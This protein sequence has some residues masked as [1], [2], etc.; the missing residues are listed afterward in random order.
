M[1]MPEF[2]F[3][4]LMPSERRLTGLCMPEPLFV[5]VVSAG[6]RVA[7]PLTNDDSCELLAIETA[8]IE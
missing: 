1:C 8:G 7:F 4:L 5:N 3:A 6:M 2:V